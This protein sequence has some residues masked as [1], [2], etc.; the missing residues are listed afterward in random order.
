MCEVFGYIFCSLR[1]SEKAIQSIQRT[2]KHQRSFNRNV[3][4][5][6]LAMTAYAVTNEIDRRKLNKKIEELGNEIKELRRP[7]GE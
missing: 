1:S 2:L 7:E 3:A 5:L 6:A 4:V